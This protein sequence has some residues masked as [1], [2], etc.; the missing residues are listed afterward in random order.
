MGLLGLPLLI[1]TEPMR[2]KRIEM[3]FEQ[4]APSGNRAVPPR[5]AAARSC[6]APC[7]RGAVSR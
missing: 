6:S 2:N 5:Y 1:V 7:G 3:L 4:L